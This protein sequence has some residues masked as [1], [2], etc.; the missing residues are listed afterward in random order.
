[1]DSTKHSSRSFLRTKFR[2]TKVSTSAA[3]IG[4]HDSS[5]SS[6]S[7]YSN[8]SITSKTTV[9]SDASLSSAKWK[10]KNN[11]QSLFANIVAGLLGSICEVDQSQIESNLLR[12][13]RISLSNVR[14]LPRIV[15]RTEKYEFELNGMIDSCIL[16]WTWTKKRGNGLVKRSS[17][18]IEGLNVQVDPKK[19]ESVKGG[20][21]TNIPEA[22]FEKVEDG[23]SVKGKENWSTKIIKQI[24]DDIAIRIVD[25][26]ISVGVELPVVLNSESIPMQRRVVLVLEDVVLDS[27]GRINTKSTKKSLKTVK[28]KDSLPLLQRF[29]IGSISSHIETHDN[30][31]TRNVIPLI[32]PFRYKAYL[33]KF[34]G[35]RF[36]GGLMTGY[37]VSGDILRKS[38]STVVPLS[39]GLDTSN[40][41]PHEDRNLSGY[42]IEINSN[43]DQIE[44]L[45]PK[46]LKLPRPPKIKTVDHEC[47]EKVVKDVL[48]LTLGIEQVDAMMALFSIIR[49]PPLPQTSVY[50]RNKY[51]S[52]GQLKN[53]KASDMFHK[54]TRDLTKASKFDL[55]LEAISLELPNGTFLS[56]PQCRYTKHKGDSIS[57]TFNG[58]HGVMVNHETFFEC[59]R[60]YVINFGDKTV[61]FK[62]LMEDEISKILLIQLST[63]Q[64]VTQGLG[65][66]SQILRK[67][68][69]PPEIPD[70]HQWSIKTEGATQLML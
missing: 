29:Q 6:S 31:G 35:G 30:N 17:L 10:K 32:D 45:L 65:D 25:A 49:I 44:T 26:R 23:G 24:V 41:I 34:H 18:T 67:Y 20:S 3:T 12:K 46:Q 70:E 8:S 7:T 38:S 21:N 61:V 59:G 50:E 16:S 42:A 19:I 66:I 13:A 2:K 54:S 27:L 56:F 33:K 51:K 40:L 9:G 48:H 43:Q 1:M 15:H 69:P 57:L 63:M 53:L 39:S 11:P 22:N 62:S 47:L 5:H 52:P 28:E 37:D 14:I 68:V 64:Q 60:E 58:K 55:P 4:K 36:A